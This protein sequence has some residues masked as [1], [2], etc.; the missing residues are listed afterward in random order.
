MI[1]FTYEC[2]QNLAKSL[3]VCDHLYTVGLGR[4][5]KVCAHLHLVDFGLTIGAP[6][7]VNCN[8]VRMCCR[9]KKQH[10]KDNTKC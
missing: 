1:C 5:A 7:V 3:S 6:F 9:V 4:I 2:A 8:C 10:K